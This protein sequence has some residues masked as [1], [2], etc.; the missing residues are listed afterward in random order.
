MEAASDSFCKPGELLDVRCRQ[1]LIGL[2]SKDFGGWI[3]E[4]ENHDRW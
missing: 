3:A 4:E 2:Y 1:G